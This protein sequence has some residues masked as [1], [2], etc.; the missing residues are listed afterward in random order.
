MARSMQSLT[1]L[2]D[3]LYYFRTNIVAIARV[4]LPI[5]VL[6]A[7]CLQILANLDE[8]VWPMFLTI[9]LNLVA[10]PLYTSMLYILIDADPAGK[11]PSMLDLLP[12]A[13]C[14]W[15]LFVALLLLNTLI[16]SAGLLLLLLPGFW[17][18]IRL[19]LAQPLLVLHGLG[20]I[21]AVR[22]SFELTRGHF[23]K[24]FGCLIAISVPVILAALLIAFI[25]PTNPVMG[26]AIS[27]LFLSAQLIASTVMYRVLTVLMAE[28]KELAA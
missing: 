11:R 16:L 26:V 20:P 10:Y 8:G 27:T 23:W 12:A 28:R 2:R 5:V 25:E 14:V 3:S 6:Q 24:I 15:P 9:A 21:G 22:K 1:V 19:S 18:S 4:C 13:L 7:I 17:I